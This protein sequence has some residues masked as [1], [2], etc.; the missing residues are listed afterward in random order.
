MEYAEG[1][2]LWDVLESVEG[3]VKDPDLKWWAVQCMSTIGWCYNQEFVHW[4]YIS[5][6]LFC[7]NSLTCLFYSPYL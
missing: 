3:T 4:Y 1:R 7:I 6:I 2:T 5:I